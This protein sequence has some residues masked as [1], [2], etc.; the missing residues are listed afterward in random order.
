MTRPSLPPDPFDQPA[1]EPLEAVLDG[2]ERVKDHVST[3]LS[4][5]SMLAVS[6]GLGWGLWP[7]LGPWSIAIAGVLLGI[8]VAGADAARAPK[9]APM[10]PP[11]PVKR[12]TVPGPSDPGRLHAKGP[13][14]TP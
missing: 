8:L 7:H 11:E 10:A 6:G 1:P 14:A 12:P 5:V 13:G 4:T 2:P 9:P 3:M